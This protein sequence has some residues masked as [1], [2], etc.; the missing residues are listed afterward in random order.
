MNLQSFHRVVC[1]RKFWLRKRRGGGGRGL[2]E[3][4]I[5]KGTDEYNHGDW[6]QRGKGRGESMTISLL[7]HSTPHSNHSVSAFPAPAGVELSGVKREERR[8]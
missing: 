8:V 4:E 6:R 7:Y 2:E 3:K 1:G 5:Y